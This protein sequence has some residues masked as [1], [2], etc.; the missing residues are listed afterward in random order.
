MGS[1]LAH[2]ESIY[3]AKAFI[4]KRRYVEHNFG[5]LLRPGMTVLE[6]GPGMG[7]FL[8]VLDGRGIT[9][10]DIVERDCGVA[11]YLA[12]RYTV[13]N[14]W[15]CPVEEL[16]GVA[17]ELRMYD[18]VYL[19]QILEHVRK[20]ALAPVLNLLYAH[21]K[22]GGR[23]A[24]VVPNGGNPLCAVERY[25]DF[26]HEGV[27]SPSSLRQLVEQAGL[28]GCRVDIEGFRIPPWPPVNWARI[29][30]QKI[31][32]L[33]LLA[34]MVANG[35]NFSTLLHPNISLIIARPSQGGLSPAIGL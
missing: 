32:H 18:L 2:L 33:F 27:F 29:S 20:E 17:G 7:E 24:A 16:A 12:E 10:V 23:I 31:T 4:R 11:A 9:D 22:P 21:L 15:I 28:D 30:A 5:R 19:S 25:A 3:S 14:R 8:S 35:G 1:Y 34:L 6:A 13:R 26:T